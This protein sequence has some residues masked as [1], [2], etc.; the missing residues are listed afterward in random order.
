M[1]S[2]VLRFVRLPWLLLFLFAIFRFIL[3]LRGVP[4]APRGNA[5]FSV[6]VLTI[7]SAL[8]WGALSKRVT[9]KH[10]EQSRW[11]LPVKAF[12]PVN[13]RKA[14]LPAWRARTSPPSPRC[15]KSP[16]A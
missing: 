11:L 8:Y 2:R 4:Y 10:P 9:G 7:V 13:W 15:A 16:W 3:G 5:M 6:V 14:T 12:D 1:V